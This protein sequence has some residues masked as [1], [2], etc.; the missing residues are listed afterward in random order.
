MENTPKTDFESP[1]KSPDSAKLS[2]H[3]FEI[4]RSNQAINEDGSE[5]EEESTPY[6]ESEQEKDKEV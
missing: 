6:S 3:A 5:K 2:M 1:I 4:E